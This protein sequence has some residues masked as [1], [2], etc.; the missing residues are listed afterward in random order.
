MPRES[1]LEVY[2]A[3]LFDDLEE[4]GDLTPTQRAQIMRY[5][6]IFTLKLERPS[7]TNTELADMLKTAHGIKSVSQAYRDIADVE[8]L[9]GDIR[10]S[11]KQFIRYLVNE[12][13]K[14]ALNTARTEG[15]IKEMIKAA[16]ALGKYNRLDQ[17]D[18]DPLPF[19]EI[20]PR[21]VEFAN[22][23][24]ILGIPEPPGGARAFVDKIKKRY[25]EVQDA[26]Y[27]DV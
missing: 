6:A 23:P 7:I 19:D 24:K 11:E 14:E 17:E 13:L 9:L 3:R 25:I 27:E 18:Q 26:E 10:S 22:D 2:R 4:L 15:N 5:R 8:R 1:T 16:A 20:V 21:A 12:S